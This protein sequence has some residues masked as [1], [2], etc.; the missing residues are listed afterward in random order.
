MSELLLAAYLGFIQGLTEFLPVSSSGHLVLSHV[1]FERFGYTVGEENL[2]FDVL[3]HLGTLAVVFAYYRKE[4]FQFVQEWTGFGHNYES[5]LPRGICRVW[6]LYILAATAV[7]TALALPFED[8]IEEAFSKPLPV[9]FGLLLT[10]TLLLL[11]R[12]VPVRETETESGNSMSFWKAVLIGAAQAV[13]V[14][15]GVS[16][17]GTTIAVALL[18]GVQ[19]AEAVTF[20][21]LLSI[22]AILGGALLTARKVDDIALAAPLIGM[23]FAAIFGWVALA[24][25]VKLVLRGRLMGF[26][27]YCYVVG[28]LTIAISWSL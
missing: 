21:F 10:G 24:L 25:L 17:S 11:T 23:L 13:A 16:R 22:P 6:T 7:T 26:A 15:P 14:I 4:L 2:F 28:L 3:L 5:T 27:I 8:Q 9:G 18:L 1:V 12:L 19:R 20:S